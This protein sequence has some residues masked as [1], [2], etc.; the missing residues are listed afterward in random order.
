MQVVKAEMVLW[1]AGF[2]LLTLV[3]NAP[4]LPMVLRLTGLNK[5]VVSMHSH[6]RP[7]TLSLLCKSNFQ[8]NPSLIFTM[9]S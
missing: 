2:V 3:I 6:Q 9:T 4:L 7:E 1:T 5:G 8:E